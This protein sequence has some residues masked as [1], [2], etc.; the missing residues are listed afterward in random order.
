M[1]VDTEGL[2]LSSIYTQCICM[3]RIDQWDGTSTSTQVPNL[4]NLD[5]AI[6]SC[7]CKPAFFIKPGVL[8]IGNLLH[9][10]RDCVGGCFKFA[11]ATDSLQ[12]R[13]KPTAHTSLSRLMIK[14]L[15][16]EKARPLWFCHQRERQMPTTPPPLGNTS[17][18]IIGTREAEF[19]PAAPGY[20]LA[21]GNPKA[22]AEAM[23]ACRIQLGCFPLIILACIIALIRTE[24]AP[25]DTIT[26]RCIV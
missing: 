5:C 15:S 24:L 2:Y 8:S 14:V 12:G 17:I 6:I 1:Y 23:P 9:G 25:R 3:F 21:G 16:G 4:F 10:N 20:W 7:M 26:C 13:Q 18:S 19:P 22:E 11:T